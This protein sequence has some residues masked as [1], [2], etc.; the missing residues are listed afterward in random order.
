MSIF[1]IHMSDKVTGMSDFW[2]EG[3]AYAV[4]THLIGLFDE[5]CASPLTSFASSDYWW[6]K[7]ASQIASNEVLIYFV[8]NKDDSIV[9]QAWASANPGG[10]AGY[11]YINGS[12]GNI[13]EIYV[14]TAISQLS[15]GGDLTRGLAVLAF[16][17]LMH[18]KLRL[19][20]A[21]HSHGGAAAAA[22]S[23]ETKLTAKNISAMAKALDKRVK[24]NTGYL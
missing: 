12:D 22:V 18:N 6:D 20:N 3:T 8:R 11:T 7:P 1:N 4:S 14:E 15:G 19:G 9:K 2:G 17:E 5:V 16:H 10:A 13:S 23:N 24:Q 21:L